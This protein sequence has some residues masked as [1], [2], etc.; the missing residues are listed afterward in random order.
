MEVVQIG[1]YRG[2]HFLIRRDRFSF[3]YV[4]FHRGEF[5]AKVFT[6]GT[7]QWRDFTLDELASAVAATKYAAQ[8]QVD[9]LRRSGWLGKLFNNDAGTN[10]EN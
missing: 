3:E 9:H 4:L 8:K 10:K 7:P 1:K 6:F 5:Y 2:A